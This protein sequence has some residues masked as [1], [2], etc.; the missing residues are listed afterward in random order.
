MGDGS[1]P[2]SVPTP[3]RLW[4]PRSQ[5]RIGGIGLRPEVAATAEH[6]GAGVPVTLTREATAHHVHRLHQMLGDVRVRAHVGP[7][8]GL[9]HPARRASEHAGGFDDE[10]AV[11]AG[12]AA[13]D[14]G[15]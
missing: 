9:R 2:M 10:V 13:R 8:T 11:D 15:T 1:S 12:D 6:A 7:G 3:M 4:K 5:V 14:L